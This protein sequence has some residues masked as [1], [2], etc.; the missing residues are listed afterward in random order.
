MFLPFYPFEDW[1]G[2]S[3]LLWVPALVFGILALVPFID[4]SP[5]RA[6][7]RRKAVMALGIAIVVGAALLVVYALVTVPQAHVQGAM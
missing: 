6:P 4:R 5:Y 1:F 7:R 2:L 3:A